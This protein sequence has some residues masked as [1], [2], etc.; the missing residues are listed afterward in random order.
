MVDDQRPHGSVRARIPAPARRQRTPGDLCL[1]VIGEAYKVPF[2]PLTVAGLI[3]EI[4]E[5]YVVGTDPFQIERLWRTVYYGEGYESHDHHQHPDHTVMGVLSAIEMACWDI[6]GKALNQ[7]IYN[8]IGGRYHDKLRS[9]TY[10]YPA[11][12]DTSRRSPHTDPE[13]AARSSLK[14]QRR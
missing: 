3:E 14:Q 9:Y 7:P 2:H 1:V 5:T 4:G 6:V 11:P 12:R 13:A 10:L 8:L